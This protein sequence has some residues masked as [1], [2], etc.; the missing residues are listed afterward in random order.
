MNEVHQGMPL[1]CINNGP[2]AL[3][4]IDLYEALL[5]GALQPYAQSPGKLVH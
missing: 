3:G 5:G 2:S 4:G 1:H